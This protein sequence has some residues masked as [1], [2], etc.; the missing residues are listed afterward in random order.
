[1]AEGSKDNIPLIISTMI[2]G[3]A[4]VF[5]FFNNL[6]STF[7]LLMLLYGFIAMLGGLAHRL[8]GEWGVVNI[9]VG[10]FG[11]I[12]LIM[13]FSID[14]FLNLGIIGLPTAEVFR[15]FWEGFTFLMILG[16]IYIIGE[17]QIFG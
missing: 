8:T 9:M 12:L 6:F 11:L 17:F 4:V 15:A 7:T 2:V 13:W 10:I 1:M 5:G 3:A 16:V 14:L